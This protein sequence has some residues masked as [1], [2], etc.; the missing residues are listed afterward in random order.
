[1]KEWEV[2][3]NLSINSASVFVFVLFVFLKF[4]IIVELRHGTA[5]KRACI[6]EESNW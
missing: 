4:V 6:M 3:E 5:W 1:M 2:E